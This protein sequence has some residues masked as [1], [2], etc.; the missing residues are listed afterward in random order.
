[1][2]DKYYV[3]SESDAAA[4]KEMS[5]LLQAARRGRGG[6]TGIPFLD[7]TPDMH[8]ALVPPDGI[9]ARIGNTLGS[10]ECNIYRVVEGVLESSSGFTRTVYN[11]SA[12][13]IPGSED[14]GTSGEEAY[15]AVARDK[16]GTWLA[17]SGSGAATQLEVVTNVQCLAN[18]LTVTRETINFIG[19]VQE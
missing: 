17:L 16:W 7:Q 9:P 14:I 1:M 15:V 4:V 18:V 2:P 10:A 8:V 5:R 19:T 11:L 12:S 6:N 13:E 3:L